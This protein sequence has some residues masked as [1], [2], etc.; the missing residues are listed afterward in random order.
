LKLSIDPSGEDPA[1]NAVPVI[2]QNRPRQKVARSTSLRNL[3]LCRP[4]MAR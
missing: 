4:R 1:R 3:N 2:V